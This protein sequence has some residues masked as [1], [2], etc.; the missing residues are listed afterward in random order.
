MMCSNCL[1]YGHTK[2][3]CKKETP[4]CQKCATEGHQQADC[5][6][7]SVKCFHCSEK[8]RAGDKTCP[9]QVKEQQILD[10]VDDKK[11]T[12]QRARQIL[13]EKPSQRINVDKVHKFPTFFDCKLPPGIKRKIN[14]FAVEKCVQQHK[15]NA[16]LL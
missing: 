4:R 14:P 2:R 15:I 5:P 9:S 6:S 7:P 8:H 10:L 3:R 12:F 11:I 13:N 16:K 1:E